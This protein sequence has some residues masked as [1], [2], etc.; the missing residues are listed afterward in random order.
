MLI[1]TK[2]T[3]NLFY[4]FILI[5]VGFI[6]T[7]CRESQHNIVK[8][9]KVPSSCIENGID[10]HYKCTNCDKLFLDE[11]GET[12]VTLE[13][14]ALEV[15]DHDVTEFCLEDKY[16]NRCEK[17]IEEAKEFHNDHNLDGVCDDCASE[18]D[19]IH[20]EETNAN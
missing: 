1:R 8:V 4:I 15:L 3:K 16:C 6:F 18:V 7:S 11:K 12:E 20:H 9:D 17:L 10:E 19:V 13:D 14:L 5:V 2:I